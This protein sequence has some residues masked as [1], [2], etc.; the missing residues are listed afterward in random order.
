[1]SFGTILLHL[2]GGERDAANLQF[3][4]ALAEEHKAH[5]IALRTIT[6]FYPTI[7]AFGDAAVG[8]IAELQE[9]YRASERAAADKFRAEAERA[10]SGASVPLEWR[11]EEDFADDIVPVH[12][13]YADI[14]ILGQP[15]RGQVEPTHSAELPANV[16]MGSGRPIIVVPYAGGFAKP[17]RHVLIAWS[18]T[19]EA[20]RAVHDALP[21]LRRADKVSILSV[22][23]KDG[24]H[25]P[26]A[27]IATHLARHGCKAETS[28][29]VAT[30]ISVAD[31]ILSDLSDIGADF[32]VMGAYGHSR[33]RQWALGGATKDVLG[34]M[35]V[36]VLLAH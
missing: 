20:T 33:L 24:K 11:E 2:N 30:D 29:T 9:R 17:P 8:V 5:L 22:N 7:G 15:E 34:T 19:R 28:R 23:P 1:M 27:D 25:L 14:T 3:A 36:P 4:I 6:P 32:L 10:S 12:A 31:A 35:T 13:R 18:G 16:V 21:I 26:G